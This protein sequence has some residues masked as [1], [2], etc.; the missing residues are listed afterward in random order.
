MSGNLFYA[1]LGQNL[2]W[3]CMWILYIPYFLIL[4]PW[5]L[6]FFDFGLMYCDLWS[7]YINVRKLFKGGNYSR[8]ETI[9]GNT[10]GILKSWRT[11]TLYPSLRM[12]NMSIATTQPRRR[13][14]VF[15][16]DV[17]VLQYTGGNLNKLWQLTG[18]YGRRHHPWNSLH[19][20]IRIRCQQ[21]FAEQ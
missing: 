12:K 5:K 2:L 10:V 14:C 21:K 7:Q 16:V 15:P 4:F 17:V 11:H 8:A 3:S 18:S 19:N 9:W 6:F 1:T 13:F 20:Y